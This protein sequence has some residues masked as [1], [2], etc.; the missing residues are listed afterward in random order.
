MDFHDRGDD[1]DFRL[2]GRVL[3]GL[4]LAVLLLAGGGAWAAI[5][6]LNGS[7]I[8]QGEIK[9]DQN[10]KSIQHRD[11]GIVR[12]I[13][14]REGE[15]VHAGQVLLRLD[16]VQTRAELSIVRSQL[17]ELVARKARLLAERD[18][19]SAVAVPLT[20]PVAI[21][22]S[23]LVRYGEVRLFEGNRLNRESQKEQLRFEI[24]QI[25]EE[26][27]GLQAQQVSKALE[28][29][30]VESEHK[31]MRE[32]ADKRLIEGSRVHGIERDLARLAGELGEID[33]SIARARARTSSIKLQIIGI[34]DNARTEAQRE[35]SSVATK[36]SEL[37]DRRVA[38]EDRLSRTDIR[39]PQSGIVNELAVHTIGGVITPAETVA[40]IVPEK[41]RLTVQAKFSPVDIDQVWVG[42]AT[43]LRFSAFNQR[44]TPE[45]KGEIIYVSAATMIDPATKQAHY[46]A[47][48]QVAPE[49]MA[50]LGRVSLKP[51]M[52]VEVYATTEERTAYSYL[53]RPLLDQFAKAFRE[54]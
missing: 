1:S 17:L 39:A 42:Q 46:L 47:E 20:E 13:A 29:K 43:K 12:E 41:A 4:S 19:S 6:Q 33:A 23:D 22:H 31:K 35:L 24:T 14:I 5:A 15:F 53:A 11:G 32:L 52:P 37:N 10:L 54:Q 30:L 40:T 50:K 38:I 45:L 25:G 21:S 28:L 2:S 27:K 26:I 34:D 3:A 36:L 48:I 44:T 9:V 8:A 16:D 49:E 7:I 18:G 51:G